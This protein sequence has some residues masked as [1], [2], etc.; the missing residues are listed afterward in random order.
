MNTFLFRKFTPLVALLGLGITACQPDLEDDFKPSKGSV[1]FSRYIAVGNSLTAGYGDNGL[2]REGQL[3]SYPSI[4]A[5]QFRT[6]GGGEFAQPLFPEANA[7]GSGYLTITGFNGANPLINPEAR[8][9]NAFVP[10]GQFAPGRAVVATG[11]PLLIRYTATDNQNLG[12][13][14]I[15][16]ADV[17]TTS[18]GQLTAQSN[19]GNFNTYFERLLTGTD[20]RTYLQYVQERVATVKPTFFT[21]WL[22]NNDVLGFASSGGTAAPLTA[23][24]EFTTKYNQVIDALTVDGAKGLVATIPS[25]TNVPLFTTVPTAS[26]IAQINATPIPAALVPLIAAQLKLPAGSPLPAGTR[27]GL[28]VRTSNT[29]TPVREATENDL[30]LLPAS[31]F[32][33]S[34]A[35][36]PNVFPGGIGIVIPGAPAATATALAASSNAVPN[37]LVLDASEVAA[38][39]ARTTELNAVITASAQR[40]GLAVFDANT[41]FSS[42]ARTG[43]VTNG[44][45]NN[46][47]FVSGN[48]FSLDGVHPTPR[49]YA[50]VA[51]EMIKAINAKFGA[52]V[53]TVNPNDYR[54]VRFPQ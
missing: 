38:V 21:N 42:I 54:G 29:T 31:A 18:Y 16:V 45:S 35:V 19:A 50:L 43:I 22:G 14:G 23:V 11:S 47:S 48:L 8:V 52:Q 41:Y 3:T 5:Q 33:N 26:V 20:S 13:P 51:N 25:V 1:D 30:L 12:V 17:T 49:G 10:I 6:V 32:I 34:A 4:L 53:P 7:N 28:Y 37:N 44:V 40:K 9:N 39:T 27:F 24:T 2:Y 15:R 36:A 46:T